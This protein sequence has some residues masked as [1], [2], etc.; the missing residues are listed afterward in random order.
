MTKIV[1]NDKNNLQG[2]GNN[3]PE[4]NELLYDKASSTFIVGDGFTHYRGV[5]KEYVARKWQGLYAA[6][7]S[8]FVSSADIT[9]QQGSAP[10]T[11]TATLTNTAVTAGSYTSA[12]ITVDAKGRVTAAANGSGGS[13]LQSVLIKTY[14]RC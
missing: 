12:N 11:L 8:I 9:F 2:G 7:A 10:E 14:V 13:S 1:V 4:R 3:V 6:I 5:L